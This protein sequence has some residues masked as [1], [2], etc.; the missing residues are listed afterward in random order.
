MKAVAFA[1]VFI[2]GCIFRFGPST[3]WAWWADLI[4]IA[5]ISLVAVAS[6]SCCPTKAREK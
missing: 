6:A 3:N 2:M 1:L 5:F 4:Y